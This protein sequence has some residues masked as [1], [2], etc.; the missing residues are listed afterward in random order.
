M[1]N[2]Y[3]KNKEI[4]NYLIVGVLTTLVSLITYY[5]LTITILNPNNEIELQIANIISWIFAVIFA[6]ITNRKMV[7]ESK[8]KNITTEFTKFVSSRIS[9][10][11]IE[12]FLMFILVSVLHFNDKI[13]KIIAQII[14]I[15]LN[16]I[17]SKLF[18]FTGD[19]K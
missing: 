4:I 5:I 13:M 1:I 12:M 6:Y 8:D 3:I 16:Y 19:K 7:F 9:T 11:L 14:V 15:I 17:F 2:I 10:L 18:V